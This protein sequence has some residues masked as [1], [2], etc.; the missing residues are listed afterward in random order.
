MMR[1]H[2]SKSKLDQNPRF[3]EENNFDW[4]KL[5]FTMNSHAYNYFLKINL[6]GIS[7]D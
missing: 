7:K 2:F 6:I 5:N 3:Y 1:G 4:L